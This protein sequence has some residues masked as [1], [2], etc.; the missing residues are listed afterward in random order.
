[1]IQNSIF[2]YIILFSDFFDFY[3]LSFS[4]AP[5][6]HFLSLSVAHLSNIFSDSNQPQIIVPFSL[7]KGIARIPI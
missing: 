1:M 5:L 6:Y 7:M 4:L 3:V 2:L